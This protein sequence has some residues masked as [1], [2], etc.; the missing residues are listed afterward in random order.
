MI[1]LISRAVEKAK[2]N[3]RLEKLEKEVGKR[4]T[5]SILFWVSQRC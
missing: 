1:P 5:R 2:M 3:V 4:R